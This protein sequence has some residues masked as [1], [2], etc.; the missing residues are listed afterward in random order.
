MN[1]THDRSRAITPSGTV[2]SAQ[3]Y[4]RE[5]RPSMPRRRAAASCD[6]PRRPSAKRYSAA[7]KFSGAVPVVVPKTN[8]EALLCGIETDAELLDHRGCFGRPQQHRGMSKHHRVIGVS[9]SVNS[10]RR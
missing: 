2:C 8:Y 3:A 10:A 5:L 1:H 9:R 7:P 6:S 4:L